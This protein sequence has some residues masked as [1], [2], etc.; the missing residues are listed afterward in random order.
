MSQ[1]WKGEGSSFNSLV[2]SN[3]IVA[4]QEHAFQTYILPDSTNSGIDAEKA[5]AKVGF[6][7]AN[8][9]KC[10]TNEITF[11]RAVFGADASASLLF[12]DTSAPWVGLQ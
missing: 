5:F 2:K 9:G 8:S 7:N 10:A 1:S 11:Q 6:Q 4:V 3:R 12:T